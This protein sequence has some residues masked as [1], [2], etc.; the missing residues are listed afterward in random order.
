[1]LRT[2]AV[3]RWVIR[4]KHRERL[5]FA[6]RHLWP[7]GPRQQQRWDSIALEGGAVTRGRLTPVAKT[8]SD[9]LGCRVGPRRSVLTG[10]PR[11]G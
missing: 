1:M 3:V 10:A 2:R 5:A 8:A 11:P 6:D 9:Y 4:A 7:A